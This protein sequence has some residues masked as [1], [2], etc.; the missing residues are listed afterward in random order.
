MLKRFDFKNNFGWNGEIDVWTSKKYSGTKNTRV[1]FA[2]DSQSLFEQRETW[3]GISWEVESTIDDKELDVIIIAAQT[4]GLEERVNVLSPW[5]NTEL[6]KKAGYVDRAI[7]TFGGS[8]S[9][10]VNFIVNTILPTIMKEYKLPND[11]KKYI[12]G[13]SMGGYINT[14]ALA[15]YPEYFEGFGIFSPAYWYNQVIF[16]KAIRYI[17][18]FKKK[19]YIDIGTNE[20]NSDIAPFYLKDAQKAHEIIAEQNP[21]A[22]IKYVE[23]E[24]AIHSEKEWAVRFKDMIEWFLA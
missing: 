12:I 22:D 1:I 17:K 19:I 24:G 20:G 16:P 7:G 15:A 13:S 18:D 10:Y 21:D 5:T 11:A 6:G 4:P 14:Y 8:G 3:N 9:Y 2:H 23:V